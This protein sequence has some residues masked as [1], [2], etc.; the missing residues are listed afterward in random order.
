MKY[1][2]IG[3]DKDL[4]ENGFVIIIDKEIKAVK[5]KSYMCF[6]Y[7]IVVNKQNEIIYWKKEH[8]QDL[9]DK[10]LTEEATFTKIRS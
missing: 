2:F 1:K 8:I 7:N 10:G 3:T 4:L 6:Y 5:R 9:I